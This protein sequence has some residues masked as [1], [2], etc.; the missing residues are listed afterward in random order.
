[1]AAENTLAPTIKLTSP[2][3]TAW[4]IKNV[5]PMIAAIKPNP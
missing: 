5:V 2:F 3:F 1:M 4:L